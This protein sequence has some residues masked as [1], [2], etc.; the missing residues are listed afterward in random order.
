MKVFKIYAVVVSIMALP[1]TSAFAD[2]PAEMDNERFLRQSA[3]ETIKRS[4]EKEQQYQYQKA[5]GETNIEDSLTRG[6][7]SEKKYHIVS[8]SI[9]EDDLFHNS[10][11]RN[12]ILD[13]YKNTDM[14]RT[15][16]MALI[17]QLTNFYVGKGYTST[18]VSLKSGNLYTGELN[19]TVLWGK[20]NGFTVDGRTE[21]GWREK[22]RVYA[23]APVR[24]GD[25]L[26]IQDLDQ[27]LD[28][29][30]KASPGI[31]MKV[32]ASEKTGYSDVNYTNTDIKYASLSTGL[33]NS[34]AAERGLH[35]YFVSGYLGNIIGVNDRLSGRYSWYDLKNNDERQYTAYGAW[36]LPFGYWDLDLSYLYSNYA[37]PVGGIFG[38]YVSEGTS[39]RATAKLSRLL[40]RN[41][42]GKLSG[43]VKVERRSSANYIEKTQIDVSTKDYSN[44]ATGIN[45]VGSA[46]GGWIYG[47]L[48][49]TAGRPWFNVAWKGDPDLTD[50]DIDFVKYNGSVN[51]KK[52][53]ASFKRIGLQYDGTIS[54]QY[55]DD[56]LVSSEQ[57]CVGDEYTVRGY[58]N[59]TISGESGAV[60]SSN[61]NIPFN[62][63]FDVVR[64]VIPFVGYDIGLVRD[65][66]S[67]ANRQQYISGASVGA[68]FYSKYMS[69]SIT[70]SWP[71]LIPHSLKNRNIDNQV[72]YYNMRVFF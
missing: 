40:N 69:A 47:D 6:V 32:K 14:G 38:S 55:T 71:L 56:V 9:F 29:M 25:V 8:I 33:N 12:D 43:W 64:G 22:L 59:N 13:S 2:S 5:E 16:I 4:I 23:A 68:K 37:Q 26:N 35:Q 20:V 54:F 66:L 49:V 46:L 50:Y 31:A 21:L 39:E 10:R 48:S 30:M 15:E 18:M 65:N 70:S 45:Y 57:F 11:E 7:Q 67:V 60:F 27:S 36:N 51:W 44:I 1:A 19:L 53:I 34:G 52:D 62:V 61:I 24:H 58:K 28:N 41:A 3:L 72:L 63:G 42:G 17:R